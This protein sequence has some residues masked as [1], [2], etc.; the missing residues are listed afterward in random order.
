MSKPTIRSIFKELED[1]DRVEIS[2]EDYFGCTSPYTKSWNTKE[3][4]RFFE[5]RVVIEM[6]KVHYFCGGCLRP[7]VIRGGRKESGVGL[8]FRHRDGAPED[9]EYESPG[10]LTEEQIRAIKYKGLQ[11]SPL[12]ERLKLFI[13]TI[14]TKEGF[15]TE[16]EKTLR[17]ID[18][19]IRRPDV[20]ALNPTTGQ[21]I[22]FEIQMTTTFLHVVV[23]RMVDYATIGYPVIWIFRKFA[24]ELF[25][26]KDTYQFQNN[27]VFVLDEE[28]EKS[29]VAEGRLHLKVYFLVYSDDGSD[30]PATRWE[31]ET[32]T[33]S[34]LTFD[35]ANGVY[36]FDSKKSRAAALSKIEERQKQ[37][38]IERIER[39]ERDRKE[40]E[41]Y[42]ARQAERHD[43]E[44]AYQK[45]ETM[46]LFTQSQLSLLSKTE[47]FHEKDYIE[48]FIKDAIG[49]NPI[50]TANIEAYIQRAQLLDNLKLRQAKYSVYQQISL[51]LSRDWPTIAKPWQVWGD[52]LITDYPVVCNDLPLLIDVYRRGYLP[53]NSEAFI[54]EKIMR[55][56]HAKTEA[57]KTA[58][59][60]FRNALMHFF[61]MKIRQRC[62]EDDVFD[63]GLI[64][65]FKTNIG[66]IPCR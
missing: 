36:Y 26:T 51:F 21:H 61:L 65:Y 20:L 33:I 39:A 35:S 7:V 43:I 60:S 28:M 62:E 45:L 10:A 12:H 24:P 56:E 63:P 54:I 37:Q 34:D 5:E 3:K 42:M 2:S 30:V 59:E 4:E 29:S 1:G 17:I 6:G 52:M 58:P 53:D 8:H 25:T 55:S 23:E 32:I 64:E 41:A 14:L 31:S 49:R 11:E 44:E 13:A 66:F 50:S 47:E 46:E 48:G 19:Q 15:T 57:N 38:R 27:N 40:R 9:C 18:T 22:V 16:V